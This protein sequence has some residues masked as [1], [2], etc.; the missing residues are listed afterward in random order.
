[1]FNFVFDLECTPP[2]VSHMMSPELVVALSEEYELV[3]LEDDTNLVC[4]LATENEMLLVTSEQD[5]SIQSEQVI[6]YDK[7]D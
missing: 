4:A 2:D 7:E 1:M 6:L 3:T 5:L